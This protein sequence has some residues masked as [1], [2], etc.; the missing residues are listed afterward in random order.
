MSRP[1]PGDGTVAVV[2][3]WPGQTLAL[4]RRELVAYFLSPMSYLVWGVFLVAAGYLFATSLR[5]G[6]SASMAAT[7]SHIGLL[8]V[9]VCPLLTM[10]LVAEEQKMGT[11]EVLMSDPVGEAAVICGKFAAAYVFLMIML[12]PTTCYPLILYAAGKPDLGP[13]LA[14]YIGLAVLG[15]LFVSVGLLASASTSSQI[16]AAALSFTILLLF[17]AL[18]RAARA[19]SPGTLQ[20]ALSYLSAFSRF[21][22]FRRGLVDTRSIMY[23]F[24]LAWLSLF[25]ATRLVGMRRLR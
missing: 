16:A 5:D 7:F 2:P 23:C 12:L 14:G 6:G 4:L 9:F 24:S 3:R 22:D 20:D 15:A 19:A 25:L 13:V 1:T 11:L 17:W 8:L 21:N 10:H 18:S